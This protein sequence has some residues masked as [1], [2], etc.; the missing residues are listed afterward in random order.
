MLGFQHSIANL[1][2]Y[3]VA[4]AQGN[5]P[6]SIG[7]VVWHNL[8]PAVLGNMVGGSVMVAGIFY[9]AY[10]HK[11]HAVFM[12]AAGTT[13]RSRQAPGLV[14][15]RLQ[16]TPRMHIGSKEVEAPETDGMEMSDVE[17]GEAEHGGKGDTEQKEGSDNSGDVELCEAGEEVNGV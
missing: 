1:G 6:F 3:S 9:A 14:M 16:A 13:L 5:M 15:N 4:L 7:E 2:F 12:N 11:N 17:A 8:V 10:G